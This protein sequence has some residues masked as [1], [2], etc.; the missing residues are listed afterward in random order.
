MNTECWS[1]SSSSQKKCLKKVW[2]NL[3]TMGENRKIKHIPRKIVIWNIRKGR[4]VDALWKI[5]WNYHIKIQG[6]L[7][8]TSVLLLYI[9]THM[10]IMLCSYGHHLCLL[11][12][13]N[14]T[15]YV[16]GRIH[17]SNYHF[18]QTKQNVIVTK[19]LQIRMAHSPCFAFLLLFVF[20][21]IKM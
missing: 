6:N 1:L 20:T 18:C 21:S 4:K 5:F 13:A 3:P 17:A 11:W 7:C 12:D 19:I 9:S 15:Q 16:D 10:A 2:L 8:G 14:N